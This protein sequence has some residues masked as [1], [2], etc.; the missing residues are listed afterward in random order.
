MTYHGHPLYRSVDDKKPGDLAGQA[1]Y[2][3][4][5]VLSPGGRPIKRK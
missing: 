3:Y 4:W 2:D 5:Y 1:L